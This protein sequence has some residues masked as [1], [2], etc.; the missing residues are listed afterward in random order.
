M[1][2]AGIRVFYSLREAIAAGYQVYDRT[3]KGWLVRT[4]T[5]NGFALAIVVMKP[6]S[7]T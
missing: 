2:T 4:R 1:M 7:E 3:P 5:P 6:E